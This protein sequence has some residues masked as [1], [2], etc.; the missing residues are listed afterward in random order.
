MACSPGSASHDVN[1]IRTSGSCARRKRLASLMSLPM[2]VPHW[3]LL[4]VRNWPY[5]LTAIPRDCLEAKEADGAS[6]RPG[7]GRQDK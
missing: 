5:V 6:H 7:L 3:C 1:P 4:I 2:A